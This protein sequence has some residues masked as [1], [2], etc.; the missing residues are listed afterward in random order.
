MQT[1]SRVRAVRKPF[2]LVAVKPDHIFHGCGRRR[3]RAQI[4]HLRGSPDLWVRRYCSSENPQT[5]VRDYSQTP[6][7]HHIFHGRRRHRRR[8]KFHISE[9]PEPRCLESRSEDRQISASDGTVPLRV[10]QQR[11]S[12]SKCQISFT[13]TGITS[14]ITLYL[15]LVKRGSCPFVIPDLGFVFILTISPCCFFVVPISLC[16]ITG[17]CDK[18]TPFAKALGRAIQRQKLHPSP[19][20]GV[21]Q[22]DFPKGLLLRGSVSF[23]DAGMIYLNAKQA[24]I[25]FHGSRRHCRSRAMSAAKCRQRSIS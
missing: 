12:E 24:T 22:A 15:S 3:H 8:A 19:R 16:I 18:T 21:F 10:H 20:F 6:V 2:N 5:H 14:F 11:V 13:D 23:T 1:G 4:P 9:V 17:V 7:S 25:L